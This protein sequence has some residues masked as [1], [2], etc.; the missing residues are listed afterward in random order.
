MKNNQYLIS[1]V[2]CSRRYGVPR[3]KLY[4]AIRAGNTEIPY[5]KIGNITKINAPLF[6]KYLDEKSC[7]QCE[8]L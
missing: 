8:I 2:E 6:E 5:T 4:A 7:A 1:I 3:D